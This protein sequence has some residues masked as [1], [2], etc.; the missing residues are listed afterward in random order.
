MEYQQNKY[1]CVANAISYT[2]IIELQDCFSYSIN[3]GH[4]HS[5]SY[6]CICQPHFK[7][8]KIISPSTLVEM[9]Q[10]GLQRYARPLYL[11]KMWINIQHCLPRSAVMIVL[12]LSVP[13]ASWTITRNVMQPN[14][15]HLAPLWISQQFNNAYSCIIGHLSWFWEVC[16]VRSL[17]SMYLG[18]CNED[19]ASWWNMKSNLAI[20]WYKCRRLHW[21]HR[22]IYSV[23]IPSYGSTLI[24]CNTILE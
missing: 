7:L 12:Q 6:Q 20:Q 16:M 22:N 13:L 24:H 10:I 11:I 15:F 17:W 2:Y 21:R 3:L 1:F 14:E 19:I 5:N 8:I 4:H 18:D 23:D 9:A